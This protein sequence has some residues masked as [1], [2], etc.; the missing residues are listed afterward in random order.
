MDY[1]ADAD[2]LITVTDVVASYQPLEVIQTPEA[3]C[4][5][6]RTYGKESRYA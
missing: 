3:A 5:Q 1:I 4:S 6:F 2:R